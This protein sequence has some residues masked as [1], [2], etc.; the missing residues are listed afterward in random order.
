MQL[1]Y[2]FHHAA[3]VPA[4]VQCAV[5]ARSKQAKHSCQDKRNR[6]VSQ[7]LQLPLE[8][9]KTADGRGWGARCSC[10]IPIGTFVVDYVGRL[11]TDTEA[12]SHSL[13]LKSAHVGLTL[14]QRRSH[15]LIPVANTYQYVNSTP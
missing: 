13:A 5:N 11:L 15:L 3:N 6:V 14:F 9:F 10:D 12:V 4:G 8:I 2:L 1:S 7:G